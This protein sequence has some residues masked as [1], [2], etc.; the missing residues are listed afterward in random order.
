MH[1]DQKYID[2]LLKNDQK[3][4]YELYQKCFPAIR[5][6]VLKNNGT[7]TDAADIFQDALVDLFRKAKTSPVILHASICAYLNGMCRNKWYDELG[8]KKHL[9]E[10]FNHSKGNNAGEESF[11]LSEEHRLAQARLNL[12]RKKFEALG[13]RCK[14]LLRLSWRKNAMGKRRSTDEIAEIFKVT[15]GYVRKKKSECIVKLIRLVMEDPEFK[16]LKP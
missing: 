3:L 11:T 7:E 9:E 16:N 1:P 5:T 13:E 14:E 12:I 10:A 4:L 2:A 15:S 6:T 8:K